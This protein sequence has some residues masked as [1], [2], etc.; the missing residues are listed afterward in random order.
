MAKVV[1]YALLTTTFVIFLVLSPTKQ[2]SHNYPDVGHRRL[3]HR[4]P[5]PIFDPLVSK[6]ESIAKEENRLDNHTNPNNLEKDPNNSTNHQSDQ[7]EDE[8]KYFSDD[9]GKLNITLRLMVLFPMIDF[10]PHDGVIS[11]NEL[12][13]WNAQQVIDRLSYRTQNEMELLDKNGDGEISFQEYLPHF[14]QEEIEQNRMGHG[15]AGWWKKQFINADADKNGSLN[16]DEFYNFLNPEDCNNN[17]VIKEWLLGEKIKR[18]YHDNDGKLNFKEFLNNVYATFKSC[19]DI[20]N[21]AGGHVP[22]PEQKFEELDVNK[23]QLLEVG[24]M[25][26]LFGCLHPGELT[27][28]KYYT[29]YLM[30]EADD[31]KDGNLSLNEMLNHEDMFYSAIYD[32]STEADYDPFHDEL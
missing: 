32:E 29:A 10:A 18:M 26:P 6:M 22:S 30:N 14:S 19:V 17:D 5:K 3:G 31:N 21:G 28:A 1:V 2:H 12:E 11:F 25:L 13:A 20:V 24:E 9:D 8:F 27:Y 15:E 23:N 7:V 4:F 16:F